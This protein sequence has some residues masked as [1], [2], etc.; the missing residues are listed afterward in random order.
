MPS[1]VAAAYSERRFL[2]SSPLVGTLTRDMFAIRDAVGFVRAN[3]KF[4]P[5]DSLHLF[6]GLLINFLLR[7]FFEEVR[8]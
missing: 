4:A 6:F 5:S 3:E 8:S 7:L 1:A 2:S